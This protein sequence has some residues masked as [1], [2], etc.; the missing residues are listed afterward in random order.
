MSIRNSA[1]A[2]IIKS[3]KLLLNKCENEIQGIYY[4]LPGGGQNQNETMEEAVKRECLEET[5][6]SI[7]V[8][9]MV[10]IYEEIQTDEDRQEN[11]PDYA[12]KIFHIFL[13]NISSPEVHKPVET[14]EEQISSEWVEISTLSNLNFSP[15]EISSNIIK[16]I[17]TKGVLFLGSKR[18]NESAST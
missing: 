11:Y 17:N 15:K 7:S 2:I 4:T 5:G 10:G 8:N 13:C 1:K 12:H 6:I 3:G 18:K 9:K 16:L 14:D